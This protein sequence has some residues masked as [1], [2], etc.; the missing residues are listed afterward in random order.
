VLLFAYFVKIRKEN[1]RC[2]VKYT[3]ILLFL[4]LYISQSRRATYS[5]CSGK[6]YISHVANFLLSS[7]VNEFLKSPTFIK[8]MNKCRVVCFIDAQCIG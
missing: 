6:Y 8:V 1:W 2:C 4:I 5:S 7:A 3:R